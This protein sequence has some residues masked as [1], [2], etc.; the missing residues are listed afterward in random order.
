[1][2]GAGGFG[3]PPGGPPGGMGGQ[4]PLGGGFPQG[5]PAFATGPPGPAGP[6]GGGGGGGGDM[7]GRGGVGIENLYPLIENLRNPATRDVALQVR[8]DP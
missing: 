4:P 7:G 6:Q 3:P 2:Q 8:T 1:M 5:L